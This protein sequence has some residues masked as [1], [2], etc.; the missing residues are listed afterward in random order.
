MIIIVSKDIYL[1]FGYNYGV[2]DEC[3]T[4]YTFFEVLISCKVAWGLKPYIGAFSVLLSGLVA[5]ATVVYAVLTWKLVSE[6][7]KMRK[8]Q[9]YFLVRWNVIY[10][11][12]LKKDDSSNVLSLSNTEAREHFL[13]AESFVDFDLPTYFDF[14]NLLK[15]VSK[16]LSSRNLSD[17]YEDEDKPC[18]YEEVNYILYSKKEG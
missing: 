1:F 7:K 13:K 2:F 18:N 5:L 11:G 8:V 6:T 16:I 15:E 4:T 10:N 14:S 12:F 17:Y 9:K 3:I